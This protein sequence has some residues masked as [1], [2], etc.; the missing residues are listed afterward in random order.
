MALRNGSKLSFQ[1]APC[2]SLLQPPA[3]PEVVLTAFAWTTFYEEALRSE[4]EY[5]LER[6]QTAAQSMIGRFREIGLDD[7]KIHA[8]EHSAL[9]L[10]LSDLRVLRTAFSHFT[11]SNAGLTVLSEN[12]DTKGEFALHF[13][14]PAFRP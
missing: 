7:P 13:S 9:C 3:H 1:E 8:N 2:P 4:P 14:E 10:A 12:G 6:I 5:L 11:H